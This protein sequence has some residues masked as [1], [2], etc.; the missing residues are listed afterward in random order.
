MDAITYKPIGV[1]HSPFNDVEGVPIQPSAASGVKG[2][3]EM[4]PEMVPGLKDLD[5][6]SH[7]ILVYH[8]HLSKDYS[9]EVIPFLDDTL[10][11]VFSTRAPRRPNAIGLSVVRLNEV[12]GNILE[13]EDVDMV[14]GTPLLDVKPFVPAFDHRQPERVGWLAGKDSMVVHAV[15]D[16]RFERS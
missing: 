7:I 14:D 2:T 1:I 8:F 9:L 11:G 10:R 4:N 13:I 6:F 12:R 16:K 5:G 15:A 3:I